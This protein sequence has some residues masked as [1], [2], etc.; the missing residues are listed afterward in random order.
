MT[1]VACSFQL[2]ARSVATR[3]PS[4]STGRSP[5]STPAE[6]ALPSSSIATP[7]ADPRCAGD[8]VAG[9]AVEQVGRR[10]AE[11][12]PE[13]RAAGLHRRALPGGRALH[14]DPGVLGHP[15]GAHGVP[16]IG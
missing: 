1:A 16:G 8:A 2:E 14:L 3:A 6:P 9:R 11:D 10:L 15:L 7:S 4:R 5:R 12:V 13:L